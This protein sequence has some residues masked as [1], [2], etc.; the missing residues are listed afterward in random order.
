MHMQRATPAPPKHRRCNDALQ[1][2]MLTC[3]YAL[4]HVCKKFFPEVRFQGQNPNLND[5]VTT[6][7][8]LP[9][10]RLDPELKKLVSSPGAPA[11]RRL[12]LPAPPRLTSHSNTGGWRGRDKALLQLGSACQ[13]HH[14][15][16]DRLVTLLFVY[17]VISHCRPT[18][19]LHIPTQANKSREDSTVI[20]CCTMCA[21]LP[22][23]VDV[24]FSGSPS[25]AGTGEALPVRVGT[26]G[27]ALQARTRSRTSTHILCPCALQLYVEDLPTWWTETQLASHF[28]T[29]GTITGAEVRVSLRCCPCIG[30]YH[31]VAGRPR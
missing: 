6:L 21:V 30:H 15:G 5:R 22:E 9:Q 4:Q 26:V 17:N 23:F 29:Y 7:L 18:H 2:A 1:P 10:G 8:D 24:C 25:A 16:R 3:Y 14:T 13:C 20:V 31:G 12:P 27:S 28:R 19:P 11:L